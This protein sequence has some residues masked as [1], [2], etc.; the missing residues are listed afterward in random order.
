[1]YL[2]E[3][4]ISIYLVD[5]DGNKEEEEYSLSCQPGSWYLVEGSP[6]VPQSPLHAPGRK[7]PKHQLKDCINCTCNP[8]VQ[9]LTSGT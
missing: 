8:E 2:K 7:L 3:P 5:G 1:M 9:L 4:L 6:T